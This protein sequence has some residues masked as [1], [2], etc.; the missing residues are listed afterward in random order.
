MD[1]LKALPALWQ[2]ADRR[3]LPPACSG[4]FRLLVSGLVLAL[5]AGLLGRD[6][7]YLRSI[8]GVIPIDDVFAYE[9]YA[10][11][12]WRGGQALVDSPHTILCADHRWLFWTAPPRAFHTMPREYPAPALAVFSLPL[13]W[14]FAPY[15]LTYMVLLAAL[16]FGVA[17]WLARQRLELSCLAF[18]LSMAIGGWATALARYDLLP[19]VLVLGALVAAERGRPLVAYLL[20]VAATL[21]KIYPGFLIP[22]LALHQ[23]RTE[24]KAPRR[25]LA[26][27]AIVLVAG[28]LPGALLN[29]GGFVGPLHY[30]ALRPPQIE[31]LAGALL[32]LAG[33]IAG[34]V[35]VRL[36]YHSVNVIGA[37]AGPVAWLATLGL[38]AGLLVAY[39]RAWLGR[40]G[41]GR[42]FMLVL[43]VTLCGSKLLSPQ[44][45][46]WLFP[47]AA[48]AEGLRLRWLLVAALTL[49]IYPYGYGLDN[50]LIRLPTH[51]LFMGAIL[52]RDGLLAAITAFYLAQGAALSPVTR[53]AWI[54]HGGRRPGSA[55][56]PPVPVGAA[57][58][59][60]RDAQDARAPRPGPVTGVEVLAED[61]PS[62]ELQPQAGG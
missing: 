53:L 12:F 2:S 56:V 61:Q 20:L 37:L 38:A 32:W 59:P 6:L 29:P 52:A 40:D 13:L 58:G 9:C 16:V 57:M 10:R 41:L 18:V 22:A 51:P 24:G 25:E 44:Y 34:G 62:A 26:I 3:A 21:L 23:W 55:G 43:L 5:A 28:F 42:S 47:L 36:T 60:H 8:P 4:R 14:P 54:V 7:V 27:A 46:L 35:R 17:V 45:L 30:N 11:A 50:S 33:A 19:G 15:D 39:R 1:R 49:L 48:Y 31:S